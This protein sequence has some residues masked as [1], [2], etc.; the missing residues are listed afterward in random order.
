MTIQG[1][2]SEFFIPEKGRKVDG[3]GNGGNEMWLEQR[4]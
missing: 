2:S 1:P 3:P 4:S